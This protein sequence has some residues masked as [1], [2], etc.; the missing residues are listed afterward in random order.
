MKSHQ[1]FIK[2]FMSSIRYGPIT[3]QHQDWLRL[4]QILAAQNATTDE[5]VANAGL[6]NGK[7]L[8]IC[9][10]QDSIIV[11]HELVE[12]AMEPLKGNVDFRFIDAGHE[13]PIT[14]SEDVAGY[15]IEFWNEST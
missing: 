1:G 14:K 7:I 11:K 6:K 4:G 8:I 3:E 13:F 10:N 15:I 12:D 9:G 5:D 2:S